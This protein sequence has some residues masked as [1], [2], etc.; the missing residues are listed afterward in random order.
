[1]LIRLRFMLIT[2]ID[3]VGTLLGSGLSEY[4]IYLKQVGWR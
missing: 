1:M 2:L 3:R 4:V